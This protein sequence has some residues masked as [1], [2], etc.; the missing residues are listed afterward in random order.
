MGL[1]LNCI[2]IDVEDWF[3]ILDSDVVPDI[4]EWSG[5]PSYVE[6]NTARILDLLYAVRVKATFFWL[7]WIA[8]RHKSLLRRCVQE[9]HEI[10]SHGYAHL[11]PYEVGEGRFRADIVHAKAVLEDI[12]GTGVVGFRA[13]GFG[14]KEATS[15][16]FDV[17]GSAGYLYDAS[18]FPSRRGHGG[19]AHAPL[20]PYPIAIPSGSLF[21]I[22]VSVIEMLGRRASIFGGGY[23]RLAPRAMIK[24]GASRLKA[25]GRPLIVYVH[26]RDIDPDHPRLPLPLI[27]RFKCYVNLHTTFG[28]LKWLCQNYPFGTMRDMMD[29]YTGQVPLKAETA[30][31]LAKVRLAT[32][33]EH[34]AG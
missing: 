5:L 17:I 7:G 22:P 9:G 2:T 28:K 20:V 3:H 34:A 29:A 13:A 1:P 16:A 19:I 14:I 32:G 33:L 12:T 10:A 18:V 30:P 26:P 8:E 6:G 31:A 27:R 15:W 25:E 23:L 11:L 4:S 21:E 24:W